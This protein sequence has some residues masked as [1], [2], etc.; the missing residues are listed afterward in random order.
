MPLLFFCPESLCE[1]RL[2]D[3]LSITAP[4]TATSGMGFCK[5]GNLFTEK[6]CIGTNLSTLHF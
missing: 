4:S 5:K 6:Y 1:A 3:I 2:A